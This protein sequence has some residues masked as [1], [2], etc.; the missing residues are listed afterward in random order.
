MLTHELEAM[1]GPSTSD[2]S[3]RIGVHSGPVIAGVLRGEKS[4]FQLF[5]DTMNTT[6]RM[7]TTSE[8]N[9]IQISSATANLLEAA[10][11][12]HWVQPRAEKVAMKGKGLVQTYLADA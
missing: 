11:K 9:M 3:I 5:G 6:S 4:R 7:Q 1:L 2:L 8:I 10:G 12:S